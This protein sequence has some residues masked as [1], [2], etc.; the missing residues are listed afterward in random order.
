MIE[1]TS[2]IVFVGISVDYVVHIA[3][4]YI[5]AIEE[6]RKSRM[7]HAYNQIGN[8][9]LGGALTSCFSAFFLIICD[10]DALS[11][12]GILLLTIILCSMLNSLVFL[13]SIAFLIGP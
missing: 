12:F 6:D 8:A 9:I 2:L 3:H 4:Q 5:D 7:E 11:K 10:A 13:P 1:S